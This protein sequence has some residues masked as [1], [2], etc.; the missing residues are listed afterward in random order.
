MALLAEL[1]ARD[2]TVLAELLF[3]RARIYDEIAAA[4]DVADDTVARVTPGLINSRFVKPF[5]DGK[6]FRHQIT[7]V[8]RNLIAQPAYREVRRQVSSKAKP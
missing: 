8:G 2:L 5:R 3:G 1:E 6:H 4:L 7:A